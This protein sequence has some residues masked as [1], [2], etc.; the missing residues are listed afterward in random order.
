MRICDGARNVL[1]SAL[2]YVRCVRNDYFASVAQ[3]SVNQQKL[4]ARAYLTRVNCMQCAQDDLACTHTYMAKTKQMETRQLAKPS[5]I[6]IAKFRQAPTP[7]RVSG[8]PWP[9]H[10]HSPVVNVNVYG[11]NHSGVVSNF[12]I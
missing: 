6:P 11:Y 5:Y 12:N 8:L 2:R 4:H 1:Q 3:T 7:A 10:G 9:Y